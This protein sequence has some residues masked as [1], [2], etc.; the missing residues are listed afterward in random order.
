[1]D[2]STT[3]ERGRRVLAV[4]GNTG[5]VTPSGRD[6]TGNLVHAVTALRML[7]GRIRRFNVFRPFTDEEVEFLNTECSH[8]VYIAANMIRLGSD[9]L[10]ERHRV[11]ADN[12]TRLRI[13]VVVFGL[14]AQAPANSP[15]ADLSMPADSQRLARLLSELSVEIAVRGEFTAEVLGKVGVTNTVVT[16]CQS[17]FW[18]MTPEPPQML[19]AASMDR[20]IFGFTGVW[21]EA[22]L[23]KR[24]IAGDWECIGQTHWPEVALQNGD[25]AEFDR[26]Y[27]KVF[28]SGL[29][30]REAYLQYIK[31]RFVKFFDL[32][33]WVNHV[34]GAG[35]ALGTRFHG[36]MAALHAGVP[37]LWITHD[38]RTLELCQ[39]LGLPQVSLNE[40]N[41]LTDDELLARAD[42]TDYVR[43][44]AANYATLFDYLER[45]GVPHL[46]T[47][48]T[49][50]AR[51]GGH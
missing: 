31:R 49:A 2:R 40:A 39:H 23:I 43:K 15:D 46:L 27:H 25:E 34:R 44:Y 35:F 11:F 41:Q 50:A 28:E 24:A 16:G 45:A 7:D 26:Q 14:G 9:A 21:R 5:R 30:D 10:A 8:F 51:T 32:D 17:A 38:S 48:P 22:A 42:Y 37:A 36:N 13:P 20:V 19:P 12:L 6:N 3:S 29:L 18:R 47:A 4:V 33:E 1:M